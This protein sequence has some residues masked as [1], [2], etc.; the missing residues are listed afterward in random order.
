MKLTVLFLLISFI[1]CEKEEHQTTEPNMLSGVSFERAN[2]GAKDFL[3]DHTIDLKNSR[4]A[5]S[6]TIA[7]IIQ[8]AET[9]MAEYDLLGINYKILITESTIEVKDVNIL[10]R[11][12]QYTD[13]DALNA[14]FNCPEGMSLSTSCWSSSCVAET[15]QGFA[16]NFSSGDAFLVE[17][18]GAF[19]GVKIC[20][21]F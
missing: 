13:T 6:T 12:G 11:N 17:H 4:V 16:E 9:I 8:N 2:W 15:L 1:S 20:T 19:G 14:M 5:I 10:E 21:N 18:T 7:E 3:V